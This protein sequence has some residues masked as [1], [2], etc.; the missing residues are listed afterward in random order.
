LYKVAAQ[1]VVG[2]ASG[3]DT[4]RLAGAAGLRIA[5]LSPFSSRFPRPMSILRAGAV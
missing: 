2:S 3:T 5:R 4:V 1:F